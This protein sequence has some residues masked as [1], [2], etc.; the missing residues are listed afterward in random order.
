MWRDALLIAGKDIK[1]EMR[2]KVVINQM[3]PFALLVLILF[4]FALGPDRAP[5]INA[6]PGLFWVSVLFSTMFA[7]QRSFSLE[8]SDGVHDSIV[9]AG[10]DPAGFFVGK[11]LAIA[12][13][14]GVLEILA[15][16]GIIIL[17]GAHVTS[18][19]VL[20][21]SCVLGTVGLAAAGTM[22]GALVSGM[23][24]R[25]TLLPLLFLPVASPVLIAGTR[26]WQAGLA[27]SHISASPWLW[28]LVAFAV[29]YICVGVVLYGPMEDM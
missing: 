3:A 22:Y 1:I 25:E 23:R 12:S 26:S 20:L 29:L 2:S 18:V 13:E 10:I 28:I 4:A 16:A 19:V 11:L 17:Y 15:A 5:L 24:L 21:S 7:I 6:T 14:L 8:A 27:G 9:L